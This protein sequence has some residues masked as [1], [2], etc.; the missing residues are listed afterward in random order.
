MIRVRIYTWLLSVMVFLIPMLA[1]A[2]IPTWKIISSESSITFT[3]VQNGA[4]A[5]GSFKKFT[6]SIQFDPNQ[7]SNSKVKIVI[8]MNSVSMSYADF[9]S[10]LLTEDWFNVKLFPDAI[11]SAKNFTKKGANQYMA[12]GSLTIRDKTVPTQIQF[13]TKEQSDNKFIVTGNTIV[14]RTQFGVGQG[15]WSDTDAIKDN[16]KISFTITAQRDIIL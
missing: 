3:G 11:F 10:A 6:G 16:V 9:T 12:S 13:D 5:S 14:K 8:D 2:E 1:H 4:P 7:L 15:E